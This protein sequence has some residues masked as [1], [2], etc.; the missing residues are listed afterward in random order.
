MATIITCIRIVLSIALLFCPA[1]S[2]AFFMLPLTLT[3]IDLKYSGAIAS[4]AATFAAI[5]EGHLIR[6]GAGNNDPGTVN[7]P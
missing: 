2:P 3:F 7:A 6:T 4:A 1:F 5:Q